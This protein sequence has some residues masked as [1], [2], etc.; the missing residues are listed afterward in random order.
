MTR[1]SPPPDSES[2][3]EIESTR[4]LEPISQVSS[5]LFWPAEERVGQTQRM[6]DHNL[7]DESMEGYPATV[8]LGQ[9]V[10]P[11]SNPEDTS[12]I[13]R[14]LEETRAQTR[15]QSQDIL[16]LQTMMAEMMSLLKGKTQAQVT[17]P[18]EPPAAIPQHT[19]TM[20]STNQPSQASKVKPLK[21]PPVYDHSNSNEWIT[22]HGILLY[23]Y[24]RDVVDRKI[25]EPS[26]FFMEL[27][28]QAVTGAA[29]AMITGPFQTMMNSGRISDALGLLKVMDDT[30]RDRNANQ[31]ASALLY[32]CKQFR[33]ESL[34]SFLP[35]F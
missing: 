26:D 24:Q 21:W 7:N 8:P 31:N 10:Y 33:D 6:A 13:Y 19:T 35:R 20:T 17:I 32:A 2:G 14:I 25:M 29:K 23:I 27:F 18:T 28:S 4:S 3:T 30:F 12:E 16:S 5:N 11:S 15:N 9:P 22:T 1:F 34:S